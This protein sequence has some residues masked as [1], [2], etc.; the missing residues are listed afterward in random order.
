MFFVYVGIGSN[1]YSKVK[2]K[3]FFP[4]FIDMQRKRIDVDIV[5]D[6]LEA[7]LQAYPGSTFIQSLSR[8]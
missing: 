4:I 5:K 6:I 8:Q 7:A 3:I 2:Y 1:H